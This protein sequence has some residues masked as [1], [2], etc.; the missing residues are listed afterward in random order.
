MTKNQKTKDVT[1]L[2]EEKEILY[3]ELNHRIKNNLQ[4]MLSLVK[5][6]ISQSPHEETKQALTITKN[7]INSFAYLYESLY[8][9]SNSTIETEEYFRHI[10]HAIQ[11]MTL[12]K[13]KI[14]YDITHNLTTDKLL[15][16]TLILNEL[17]TNAFKYAFEKEGELHVALHKK[18]QL[19]T[20]IVSDNG[21]G[22][23]PTK[24]SNGLGLTIVET[25]VKNQLYGTIDI[26]VDKGTTITLSWEEHE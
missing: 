3:K 4:M 25:L 26:T 6:Q 11:L 2:L 16:V 13:V 17:V 20:M 24:I 23:N 21:E 15:Y 5:L 1:H 19:V 8:Q 18:K 9:Q 10:I 7:R 22:F 14:I 12:K